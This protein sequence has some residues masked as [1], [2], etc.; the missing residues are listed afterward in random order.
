MTH[1]KY[2][3]Q[4]FHFR[5]GDVIA[6]KYEII[7]R[8]G[9]GWEGEVYRIRERGTRIER[10]AKFFFPQ[11]NN[12]KT[13]SNWYARKLHKL[14]DCPILIQYHNREEIFFQDIPVLFLV[15]EYVEGELLSSFLKRQRGAHISVFQGVHLLHALAVGM[16]AVHRHREYHGDLHADNVI[17]RRHGLGFDL[18]V[19]DLYDWGKSSRENMQE[20]ICDMIKIFYDSIGGKRLYARHPIEVKEICCG[21]KR[22]LILEKFR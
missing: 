16:E 10:A 12:A 18:K 14:Q 6:D 8:L 15:S 2:H 13:I 9:A 21:L 3:I 7:T 5:T 17:I 4:S 20:D 22:T 1:S 11:R 19:L